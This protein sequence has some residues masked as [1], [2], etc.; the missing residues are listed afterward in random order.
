MLEGRAQVLI[1]DRDPALGRRMLS[2]LKDRDY[3][4]QWV[5]EEEK[6][7]NR[8]DSHLFDVLVTELNVPRVDGIRLM[9][10]ARDRNPEVCV[11][12]IAQESDIALATE[13]MRQGAADFQTPPLNMEKLEAVI[14]RGLAYQRLVYEQVELKRRLDERFGLGSLI[15]HSRQMMQVYKAVRQIGPMPENVLI[16]GEPGT[17]KD[18]IAQAIHN[19]SP[20]NDAAFV[21]FNCANLPEAVVDR[22]LF[23]A[24]AG[25]PGRVTLADGGTLFLE[26]PGDLTPA[27]QEKLLALLLHGRFE[28]VGDGKRMAG[29]VRLITATNQ[30]L[31]KQAEAGRFLAELQAELAKVTIEAPALRVRREDIPLLVTQALQQAAEAHQR[32]VMG[33]TRNTMNLLIAYDWPGNV[34]ELQNV[35]EGMVVTAH[36]P[37]PLG[38]NDIPEYVRRNTAPEAGEIRIAAGTAMPDIE[39]LAI[40]ETMK[41][42]GY[43]KEKCAKTLGIG[44]RTL[45]RKLTEYDIR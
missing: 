36:G 40:E 37:G 18:L 31:D 30:R 20:R 21:S 43:N 24:A 3:A 26:S 25:R 5:D 44:L 27:L 15:G 35:M 22:E 32:P 7:F 12:F 39:R 38:V 42:C 9:S 2:Y 41:L 4:V 1:V 23:G 28:R 34:R 8:L 10:V 6:A 45:Y 29:D 13:S 33:L 17:G 14:R 19:L 16:F 11:V